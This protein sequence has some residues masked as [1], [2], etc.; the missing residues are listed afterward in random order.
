MS[1]RPEFLSAAMDNIR[2]SCISCDDEVTCRRTQ[3]ERDSYGD[4]ESVISRGT[5]GEQCI[6]TSG[7]YYRHSND[8]ASCNETSYSGKGLLKATQGN[9]QLPNRKYRDL[10]LDQVG[11]GDR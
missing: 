11:T 4:A 3:T 8:L 1:P 10:E 9:Y 7:G 5:N 2:E 6:S